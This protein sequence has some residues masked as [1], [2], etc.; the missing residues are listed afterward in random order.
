M[1]ISNLESEIQAFR[2][3]RIV[4]ASFDVHLCCFDQIAESKDII[5]EEKYV[6][7]NGNR[8][9]EIKTNYPLT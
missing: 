4:N 6:K 2:A 8:K 7:F 9:V 1:R 3:K 5:F